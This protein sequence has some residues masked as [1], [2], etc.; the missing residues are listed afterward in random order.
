MSKFPKTLIVSV[1]ATLWLVALSGLAI[2]TRLRI[3]QRDLAYERVNVSVA[4]VA[5][6]LVDSTYLDSVASSGTRIASRDPFRLSH[7]PGTVPYSPE[8][9]ASAPV[10]QPRP[11]VSRLTLSV[12]GIVGSR[13]L[14]RAV[15]LGVPGRSEGV[16]VTSGDTLGGL[17]VR[18][19]TRDTV[20]VRGPDTSWA[21]PVRGGWGP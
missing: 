4:G 21:L 12:R 19:I 11:A 15:L 2:L 3:S 1:E 8:L 13:T 9:R 16:L 17:R 6:S 7:L 14:W 5:R 10:V 18:R 20:F